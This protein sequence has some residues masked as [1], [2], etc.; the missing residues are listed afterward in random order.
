MT[1]RPCAGAGGSRVS[2]SSGAP[3]GDGPATFWPPRTSNCSACCWAWCCW[4]RSP[5]RCRSA[6]PIRRPSMPSRSPRRRRLLLVLIASGGPF[7]QLVG[8]AGAAYVAHLMAYVRDVHRWQYDNIA[9]AYEKEDLARR[10]QVAY[11][12]RS[13]RAA[14]RGERKPGQVDLPRHHEPRDPDSDE[15]RVGHDRRP[16]A[17]RA[18]APTS[19]TSW[20]R[21]AIRRRRCC[22][23][24][25]TSWTS[26]RSRPGASTSSRWNSPPW[27]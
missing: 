5:R 24:S 14:R 2:P 22:G 7:Y 19:A 4:P 17:H 21:Y 8:I 11:D 9:L 27:S 20:E 12:A 18:V 26:P 23:S 25:T 3:A 10:L 13:C 15:R 6:R 1:S 16:G